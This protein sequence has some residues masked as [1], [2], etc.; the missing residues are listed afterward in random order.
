MDHSKV[1][2][3]DCNELTRRVEKLRACMD[4]Y[5][6]H[7]LLEILRTAPDVSGIEYTG[8][9]KQ[10]R[11]RA[12]ISFGG[13]VLADSEE[14]ARMKMAAIIN[15][16]LRGEIPEIVPSMVEAVEMEEEKE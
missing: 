7:K 14:A 13:I 3:V 15:N 2:I 12:T 10:Y 16:H 8:G 4:D 1:H 9:G 11:T 6:F 5:A